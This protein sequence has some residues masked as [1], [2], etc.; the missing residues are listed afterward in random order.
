MAG[1]RLEFTD[2][3]RGPALF[4]SHI[5]PAARLLS[6]TLALDPSYPLLRVLAETIIQQGAAESRYVWITQDYGAAVVALSQLVRGE[7]DA[8]LRTLVVRAADGRVLFTRSN[9]APRTQLDDT[10]PSLA[11]LLL[12][13]GDSGAMSL[14]M[15]MRVEG[16][17]RATPLYFAF[18]VHETP[19][20]RPAT[21][22]I[23]GMFVERWYERLEDGTPVVGAHEGEMLRVQLRITVPADRQFVALEDLLP[24]GLE[25]V[26]LSLRTSGTLGPF[27]RSPVAPPIAGR[28]DLANG[29]LWQSVFYGS[30]DSGW[31]SPWE[32][33]GGD[34]RAVDLFARELWTSTYL[35][36]SPP[37]QGGSSDR[38][39]L[40]RCTIRRTGTR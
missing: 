31:W 27:V 15:T 36:T 25:P 3:L 39:P 7:Q 37:R 29:P 16:G 14:G 5:R 19:R 4:P 18:T 22:D 33:K 30:W 11:G 6:T 28:R 38:R 24:A 8:P 1:K 21:P 40:R 35:A 12:A 2:S 32:Y 13:A 20:A 34:D 26:D 17:S 23:A 10:L 9:V